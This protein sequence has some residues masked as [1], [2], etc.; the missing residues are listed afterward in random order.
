MRTASRLTPL[1]SFAFRISLRLKTLVF[2]Y[3]SLSNGP[4]DGAKNSHLL[5]VSAYAAIIK[6][7]AGRTR[8][9]R[10]AICL[11]GFFGRGRVRKRGVKFY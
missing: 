3:L 11:R 7:R 8:T 2:A 6:S 1:P 4:V 10:A 5:R 9:R